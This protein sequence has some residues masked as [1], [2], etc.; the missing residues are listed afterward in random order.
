MEK[1]WWTTQLAAFAGRLA[2]KPIVDTDQGLLPAVS[3]A[4]SSADFVLPRLLATSRSDETSVERLWPLVVSTDKLIPPR[5]E[6]AADWTLT[7]QGWAAL[8]VKL[9]LITIQRLAELVRPKEPVLAALKVSGD[10]H[11]WLARFIDVAGEC[12]ESR[13]GHAGSI[14]D[15]L[16][17]DQTGRLASPGKLKQDGGVTNELK[18]IC[19]TMGLDVR[20]S[21][22][23][24]V[25]SSFARALNLKYFDSILAEMVSETA[26]EEDVIK[27]SLDY[28]DDKLR[29]SSEYE[30]NAEVYLQGSVRFLDYLV[31]SR[32]KAAEAIARRVPFVT[33]DNAV[34]HWRRDRMLMAPVRNWHQSAQ[35]FWTA[36]PPDRVLVDAYA[37]VAEKDLPNVT[38]GLATWGIVYAD[39]IAASTPAELKER[40]LL[41]VAEDKSQANGVTVSGHQFSQ[42]ALLQPELI[43]RCQAGVNEARAL[44]GLVLC[45]IAPNDP[46][47]RESRTVMGRRGGEEVRLKVRGALWLADLTFRAWVPVEDSDGKLSQM[48]ATA[49]TLRGLLVPSWLEHNDAGI[50]LLSERF[51]FDEL[52]H[53]NPKTHSA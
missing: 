12:C 24:S 38:P 11:W 20:A 19:E 6:L 13:E 15:G 40:R 22:L 43:N 46:Y 3:S 4:S 9:N 16:L 50:A 37:G 5:S 48:T 34:V 1:Q 23:D 30:G 29:E 21:L 52:G 47:W 42:I 41:A 44:L 31:R 2:A 7:A 32:G 49:D 51:G 35:Q 53:L 36:Y 45:H 14:L 39:P 17:P 10:K 25:L 28:L 26:A 33:L 18:D 8:D 27:E